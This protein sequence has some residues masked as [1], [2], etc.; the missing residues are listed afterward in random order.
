MARRYGY[1]ENFEPTRPRQVKGGIKAQSKRGS[2]A[3]KWWGKRWIQMLESFDIGERL[4]RGRS[5]ARKGQVTSLE[6]GKGN[7][8]A[9]VQGSR[10]GAYRIFIKLKSFSEKQWT[11]VIDLLA[12]QP[13]FVAQLLGNEMP[14]EIESIFEKAGL[15]LFPQK[16]KDLQTDCSC[17][18]WSNPCKHIAAVFYLMAEVFDGDPFLLFKLRGMEREEFLERLAKS[19][20]GLDGTAE[21]PEFEREPEPL[22]LERRAFWGEDA[23][24][25]LLAEPYPV[26]L[27]A[28]LPRRLGPLPFWRSD[29]KFVQEMETIYR[30]TS[31]CLDRFRIGTEGL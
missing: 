6:I 19:E 27:H 15:A 14:E 9:R 24:N 30:K 4:S 28:A 18:D 2:F 29:K 23:K 1:F 17:P 5:Y 16:S 31:D 20:A 12:E 21:E 3:G 8:S 7:V 10:S 26:R 13:I 25:E 11:Q 22:P